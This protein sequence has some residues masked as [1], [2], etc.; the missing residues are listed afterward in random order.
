MF[1]VVIIKNNKESSNEHCKYLVYSSSWNTFAEVSS[2][3][4]ENEIRNTT[5]KGSIT[6]INN[7]IT[8]FKNLKSGLDGIMINAHFAAME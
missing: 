8:D 3:L 5:V 6:H 2:I 1:L 4:S 7:V